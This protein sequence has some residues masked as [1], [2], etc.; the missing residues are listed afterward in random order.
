MFYTEARNRNGFVST[1]HL[2][3]ENAKTRA[4]A[5][6]IDGYYEVSVFR[7]LDNNDG[8]LVAI[9]KYGKERTTS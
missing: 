3:I 5:L 4:I 7:L 2:D 8:E 9:Y 6:S 1:T